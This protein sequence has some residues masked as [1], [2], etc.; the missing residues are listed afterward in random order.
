MTNPYDIAAWRFE[1]IAPLVD[2]SLSQA[3]LRALIRMRTSSAIAWPQSK[4]RKERGDPPVVKPIPKSTLSRWL[5]AWR[6]HGYEGLLPVPRQQRTSPKALKLERWILYAIGLA[7]EQPERSLTQLRTYVKLQFEDC[8]ISRATLA[9]HLYAHPAYAGVKALRTG[10]TRKRRGLYEASAPHECWQLD[11]KGPFVVRLM[12]G[13][14]ISVHVLSILDDFSRSILG[15]EVALGEDTAAAIA[16]FKEAAE[17]YGLPSRFQYDRGSAFESHAFRGGLARLGVHRNAVKARHPEA[18]GKIEAYHRS[19]TRWFVV[20][21]RAQEVVDREHLSQLCKAM[22]HVL[23]NRHHHRSIGCSPADRLNEQISGRAVSS[24]QLARA[25]LV[26]TEAMS[27]PK[28]GEVRLPNG[29]FRVPFAYAGKRRQF[30]FDPHSAVI[31]VLVLPDGKERELE[32]FVK[33]PLPTLGTKDVPKRGVGELQKLV[34]IWQGKERPNAQPGFGLPE[35]FVQLTELT[36]RQVPASE[37][38][39]RAVL[40][41]YR[42]FG[43]IACAPF[44]DACHRAQSAL[45]G[46]RPLSAYLDFLERQIVANRKQTKSSDGDSA[47]EGKVQP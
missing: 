43:P 16:A 34:D 24:D 14:R 21:L 40:A 39:G 46:D 13:S 19:L 17:K 20:E 9:R 37:R 35:V 4:R 33:M 12:D 22:I 41:F 38:E 36:G 28:T 44:V 27:H 29:A 3:Q 11:G 6:K 18:Q 26:D 23:Y 25:F 15:T 31:A 1:Q 32:V 30:R 45:G 8:D 42:K 47:T 10:K 2:H 7:Y 5:H